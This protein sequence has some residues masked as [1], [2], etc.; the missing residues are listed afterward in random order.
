MQASDN[1]GQTR[2]NNSKGAL[3][4][5]ALFGII[6]IVVYVGMGVALLCGAFTWISGDWDWLRWTA[7]SVLVIY[8]LFRAWRQ[9]KGI[10]SPY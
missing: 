3:S 1:G 4:I 2:K 5:R 8:G 7:G 9:F 6:M 10:D